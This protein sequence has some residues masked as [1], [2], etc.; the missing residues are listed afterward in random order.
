M[1]VSRSEINGRFGQRDKGSLL[2]SIILTLSSLKWSILQLSLEKQ[3]SAVW[4]KQTGFMEF[5]SL[6]R[7]SSHDIVRS[8]SS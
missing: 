2:S 8:Y 7:I 3:K 4:R 5:L 6:K 1:A